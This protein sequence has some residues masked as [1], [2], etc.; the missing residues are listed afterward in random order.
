MPAVRAAVQCHI[1]LLCSIDRGAG[2]GNTCR[3]L[4]MISLASG[5]ANAAATAADVGP[6]ME[7]IT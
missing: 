7:V 5:L 1:S 2:W 3:M 4:A 6:A